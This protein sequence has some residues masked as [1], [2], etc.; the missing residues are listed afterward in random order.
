MFGPGRVQVLG[1]SRDG[2]S[3][4]VFGLGRPL[5]CEQELHCMPLQDLAGRFSS[6]YI[7]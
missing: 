6:I 1:P 2:L 5:E 4:P 3:F 7:D